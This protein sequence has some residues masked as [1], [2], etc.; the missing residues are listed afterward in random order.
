M[1]LRARPRRIAV[2]WNANVTPLARSGGRTYS[3]SQA[4]WWLRT[5]ALLMVIQFLAL[6]RSARANWEPVCLT[7]GGALTAA[8]FILPAVALYFAGLLVLIVTLLTRIREQQRLRDPA[9]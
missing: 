9:R 2:V 3:R 4:H 5:G 7:A 8:G 6:T 1:T